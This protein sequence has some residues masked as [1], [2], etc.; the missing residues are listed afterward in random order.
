MFRLSEFTLIL[1][2]LKIIRIMIIYN[3]KQ[4]VRLKIVCAFYIFILS[5]LYIYI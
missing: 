1:V 3:S 4:N 2:L 5:V